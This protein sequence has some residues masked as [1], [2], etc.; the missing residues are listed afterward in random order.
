MFKNLVGNEEVKQYLKSTIESN[1]ISH[2]YMFVGIQGIGKRLFAREYAKN[3]MC[4]QNGECED[5]C[6]SCIKFKA[7][8]NPD[9][10]EIEPDG[11]SIKIDQVRELQKKIAEKPITS[12]KKVYVINNADFMTEESQNCLLKTLEEPPEYAT[13]ILIV[14]NE[15][16]ILPTIKSRCIT[17][18][19]K[20]LKNAEIKKYLPEVPDEL[21]EILQGSLEGAET[22]EK[23]RQQY[24]ETYKIVNQLING[25]I[26]ETLNTSDILY[27]DKDEIMNYL[28]Y[29]NLM[30]FKKRILKP[31]EIIEETK[32]KISSNNN[33]EMTIDYLLL[34]CWEKIHK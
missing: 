30:F 23:K 21:I 32:K 29:M 16:K 14:S 7:K 10:Y 31:I 34:K 15:S 5:K 3:I 12:K 25:T 33:Y 11:K 27:T 17:I 22:I 13:I 20:K 8:S 9:Y 1:N 24:E 4:L 18:K 2:S 19:F 6:N 26:I 28:N